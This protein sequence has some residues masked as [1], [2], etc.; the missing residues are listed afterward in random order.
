MLLSLSVVSLSLKHIRNDGHQKL[1]ASAKISFSND[2]KYLLALD[3]YNI[4]V[5]NIKNR[6][7]IMK[8]ADYNGY[9][10]V[11][12][13]PKGN[14]ISIWTER[15]NFSQIELLDF[16]KNRLIFNEK[17]DGSRLSYIGFSP[18]SDY[19]CFVDYKEKSLYM[20]DIKQKKIISKNIE[21]FM[22]NRKG[23]LFTLDRS[24]NN[25]WLMFEYLTDKENST[26]L[27]NKDVNYGV[28]KGIRLEL[29]DL[30]KNMVAKIIKI[31]EIKIPDY[32]TSR[33]LQTNVAGNYIFL[34]EIFCY[35][36][37]GSSLVIDSEK[38]EIRHLEISDVKK[39][40][41]PF[42]HFDISSDGDRI[43]A[44]EIKD[45][46]FFLL[47]SLKTYDTKTGKKISEMPLL[48]ESSD[49]L[50]DSVAMH[51]DKNI[52]AVGFKRLSKSGKKNLIRLFDIHKKSIVEEFIFE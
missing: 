37:N 45:M 24:I 13:N 11:E 17:I 19:L 52:V 23:T 8:S 25:S 21:Y 6:Q 16:E 18:D 43:A 7:I 10:K 31:P 47:M 22:K 30:D 49:H 14:L 42:S 27:A 34:P 9:N 44:I 33:H 35:T 41:F 50:I 3:R 39:E 20:V 38:S 1:G 29:Y 28:V 32:G 4:F 12:F 36:W 51:P 46:K 2:G 48:M 40:D 15:D 26:Q 5:W